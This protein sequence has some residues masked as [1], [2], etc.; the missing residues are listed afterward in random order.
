LL[1]GRLGLFVGLILALFWNYAMLLHRHYDAKAEFNA[2][3]I[4]GRDPWGLRDSIHHF[5]KKFRTLPTALYLCQDHH[6]LFLVCTSEWNKPYILISTGLLDLMTKT[7]LDSLMAL[8]ITTV[9]AR[10]SFIRY[11]LNRMAL[12][13]ITLGS[14]FDHLLPY[15]DLK[16]ALHI[17]YLVAW[18]HLKLAYSH[19]LQAKADLE[20][21]QN[22]EHPR[23]LATALWKIHGF[24]NNVPMSIPKV[25]RH[26]SIIGP[27]ESRR[28]AFQFIL[29]IELRLQFLVGY[30]PI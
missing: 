29:P 6:P 13:W 18:L 23:D 28:S 8:G 10:C 3:P 2:S 17:H 25:L 22:L 24:L 27:S 21:Y 11:T 16:I 12:S 19:A 30:F 7:E 26:Q 9:K 1:L 4:Q 5:E 14:L 15:R 20:A